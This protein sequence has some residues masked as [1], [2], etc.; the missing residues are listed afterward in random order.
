[1]ATKAG[2]AGFSLLLAP[3]PAYNRVQLVNAAAPGRIYIYNTLGAL[4]R[5]ED[6]WQQGLDVGG[7][8]AG[9]YHLQLGKQA[10]RLVVE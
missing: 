5:T 4:I 2:M 9:V 3:N 7:L 1:M 8:P 6:S 10:A